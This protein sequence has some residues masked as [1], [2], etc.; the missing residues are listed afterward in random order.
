MCI[1]KS[2]KSGIIK[3]ISKESEIGKVYIIGKIDI[4]IYKCITEDIV[5]D[6][7][8]MTDERIPY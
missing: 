2:V 4:N 3:K 7:V 6:E 1:A 5:T 8:I